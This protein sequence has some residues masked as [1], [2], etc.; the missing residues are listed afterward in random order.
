MAFKRIRDEAENV[1]TIEALFM[2]LRG[3]KIESPWGHQVDLW[4][5]YEKDAIQSTDVAIQLPTGSGKTLVGA[6][7]ADWR[8][9]KFNERVVYLC[10]TRQ[11]A[12]QVS[13][14]AQERYGLDVALLVG[15]KDNFD[16]KLSGDYLN[17]QRIAITTYSAL[18]NVNPFF[19]DPHV[20]ICDDAHAAEQYIAK[21]WSV[22]FDVNDDQVLFAALC[23]ILKDCLEPHKLAR[24]SG[25]ANSDLD[26]MWCDKLPTPRW[27]HL[28]PEVSEIIDTHVDG[29]PQRFP[30]SQIR[31]HLPACH[32]YLG[33][34]R[35][36]IRPFIPPTDAHAP[37]ANAK[38][39][40]YMSA[41]LGEGGELERITGRKKIKRLEIPKGWDKQ[42][43]G[44]RLYFF[45][46]R[47]LD[48]EDIPT[49]D[50]AM[51][52]RAGRSVVLVPDERSAKKVSELVVNTLKIPVFQARELE[53]S[54]QPYLDQK[55]SVVVAA[56]R[57]EGIDFPGD[58]SHMLFVM[59]LPRA[60]H[61]QERF[62]MDQMG[63]NALFNERV[64]TRVIQAFGRCTR[65]ATDYAA[66]VVQGEELYRHLMKQESRQPLDS[67]M[68]AE[69]AF[70]IEQAK[71]LSLEDSLENLDIF[72]KQE[73]EWKEIDQDI[74]SMRSKLKQTQF[75]G[76]DE[77]QMTVGHE[78][79][80]QYAL[81]TGNLDR[82]RDACDRV[83]NVLKNP[84]L[85]GYRAWWNY[86]AGAVCWGA[87]RKGV[88]KQEDMARKYFSQALFDA[89][90][91]SWLSDLTVIFG[92][93][94]Q[95]SGGP[96][97]EV[98]HMIELIED[99]FVELGTSSMRR[100]AVEE[101]AIIEGISQGDAD[102]F[103][104]AQRRLG[105]LLGFVADNSQD[106]GAPDPW[107]ILDVG[108]CLVFEDH[109]DAKPE[110]TLDAKKARQAAMHPNWIIDHGVV[111]KECN[112]QP[113]LVTPVTKAEGAAKPHLKDFALWPL[114]EFQDWAIGA[115]A[116][117]RKL[118][119]DFVD[120]GDLVWRAQAA[121]ELET[122]GLTPKAIFATA[123]ARRG[124]DVLK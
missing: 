29:T 75:P 14:H 15:R 68:Q 70:G 30:W 59:G 116:S 19:N 122:A 73:A 101:K 109:S 114:P 123:T 42:G 26:R 112:I 118:R 96:L 65:S 23:N 78:I 20:V 9:R 35:M 100:F 66:V 94:T 92:D 12:H 62:L 33:H 2:D 56:N 43:L 7:L 124:N 103:E 39:R 4:R 115:M 58:E 93:P 83:L 79:D 13:Q 16:P 102:S 76:I 25:E 5:A 72:L 86:C 120:K 60:T 87:H 8:R 97:P 91:V 106:Q 54:K 121:N 28:A 95:A 44:R 117:L 41:T 98:T 46:E 57:Y 82:A 64:L 6:V 24:L 21:Y 49:L 89:K 61:L 27:L 104:E 38:Q 113:V 119:R 80:Y 77:L 17:A 88:A 71:G 69:L 22:E 74:L 3:R 107:W 52:Q 55:Q 50:L 37:F 111:P 53:T 90:F 84:A 105:L 67:E 110:S 99:R 36:L 11:L 63:A 45:P 32:L 81:W 34:G 10:P 85:R 18:F 31:G 47:S 108:H 1:T 48:A 51:M 40:I